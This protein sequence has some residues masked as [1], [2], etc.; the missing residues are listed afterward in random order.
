MI[1]IK[2]NLKGNL[3]N[4]IIVFSIQIHL[5][6]E[7]NPQDTGFDNL[8]FYKQFFMEEWPNYHLLCGK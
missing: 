2:N 4:E 8:N 1:Q 7:Y 6:S 5:F 3:I